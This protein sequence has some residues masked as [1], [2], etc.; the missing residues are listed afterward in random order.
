MFV[1]VLENAPRLKIFFIFSNVFILNGK[2]ESPGM[3]YSL[4]SNRWFLEQLVDP[5]KDF[6]YEQ[7]SKEVIA[8]S[9]FQ[10]PVYATQL[11]NV[12]HRLLEEKTL[13]L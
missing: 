7:V 1:S 5:V 2:S 4:L 13:D 8:T 6:V 10:M 9:Q 3:S 11:N 12:R